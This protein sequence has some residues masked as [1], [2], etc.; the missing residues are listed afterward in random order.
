MESV[1]NSSLAI[2]KKPGMIV[3]SHTQ[4]QCQQDN[5]RVLSKQ[6]TRVTDSQGNPRVL[7]N[8]QIQ[9]TSRNVF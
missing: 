4:N 1:V 6:K 5:V 7:F 2:T 8:I 9:K 3:D